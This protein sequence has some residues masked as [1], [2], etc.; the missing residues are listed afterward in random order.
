[1]LSL[2]IQDGKA[3]A[4]VKGH[5]QPFYKVEIRFPPL[6]KKER[7]LALLEEDPSLLARI[8]A[9]GTG[10]GGSAFL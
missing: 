8:A 4:K 2:D 5:Y 7:V 10:F 1:V 6:A 9:G 3:L